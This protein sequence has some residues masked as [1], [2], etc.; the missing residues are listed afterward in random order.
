MPF[1]AAAFIRTRLHLLPVPSVP[2]ITIHTAHSG[3]GLSHLLEQSAEPDPPAP[4]WAYPWAGGVALARYILDHPR[5]VRG[6]RVLDLGSGS[7]L[8]AIAAAMAGAA[9]VLAAEIDANGRVALRLNAAANGMSV[10][11]LDA[12]IVAGLPLPVDIVLAG[13][14]FYDPAVAASML[15]FLDRCQ[16]AGQHVLVGDPYRAALPLQRLRRLIDYQVSDVGNARHASAVTSG[17]FELR[18]RTA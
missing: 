9:S 12:D 15:T 10:Q 7:G 17:V 5:T 18:P 14:V 6:H 13:D 16:A 4:Y 8:V 11:V 1:D 2:E 3:S